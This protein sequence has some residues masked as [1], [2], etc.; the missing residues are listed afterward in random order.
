MDVAARLLDV[1]VPSDSSQRPDIAAGFS[2]PRQKRVPEMRNWFSF[3]GFK[4][5]V[6]FL[7]QRKTTRASES[8]RGRRP[9]CHPPRK[10]FPGEH[11]AC[12]Q[13]VQTLGQL[14]FG[15]PRIRKECQ[16]KT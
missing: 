2:Q 15:P 5:Q 16:R 10:A 7:T 14:D 6:T 8:K 4:R 1:A 9:N 12:L 11:S 13:L 3:L